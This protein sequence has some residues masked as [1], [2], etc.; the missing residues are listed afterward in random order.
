MNA[1]SSA[2]SC[3]LGNVV[4]WSEI[5]R[6]QSAMRLVRNSVTWTGRLSPGRTNTG[7]G[8]PA[9]PVV[10]SAF[11]DSAIGSLDPSECTVTRDQRDGSIAV[12]VLQLGAILC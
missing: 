5:R 7:L 8:D 10:V 9:G 1:R 11:D 4:S 3:A 2:S 6:L 12:S